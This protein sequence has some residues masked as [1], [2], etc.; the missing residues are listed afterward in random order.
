MMT[1]TNESEVLSVTRLMVLNEIQRNLVA[2]HTDI[3]KWAIYNHITVNE[4]IPGLGYD[5]LFQEG[6]LCLC[7]AAITYD[8]KTA[9]FETYAQVVVRNGLFTYCKKMYGKQKNIDSIEDL[10]QNPADDEYGVTG[11]DA[12]DTYDKLLSD[13]AVFGLLESAKSEYGG[14]ARLGIE[15]LEL[16]A[17]GYTGAEIA[18]LWGVGQNQVGAWISRAKG[19]LRR[20]DRFMSEL[21]AA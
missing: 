12:D 10:P 1:N 9:A 17:K 6:C 21:K 15:A 20:N 5:D 7:H 19:K 8:G 4:S 3:V 14:V 11:Y 18:R 13:I 2:G 16:K